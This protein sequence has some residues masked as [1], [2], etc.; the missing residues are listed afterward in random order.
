MAQRKRY[1]ALVALAAM[2]LCPLSVAGEDT[3]TVPQISN[4][5]VLVGTTAAVPA[6]TTAAMDNSAAEKA[7]SRGRTFKEIVQKA[8]PTLK[9]SGYIITQYTY[10]DQAHKSTNGGFDLRLVRLNAQGYCFDK[11]FYRLQMEVNGEP[12]SKKSPRIVDAFIEWQQWDFLR[13][14]LGQFKRSFGFE[15]PMHPLDVGSGSYSQ[16]TTKFLFTDRCG[17]PAS[18]G[19][20]IGLQLQGDLFPA[21]DG[22]KWLHYQVGLFNGQGTNFSDKDKHKDLIGGLWVSPVKNLRI[23]GFGWNGKYTN[24][25]YVATD[26]V[27]MKSCKRIRWGVGIDYESNWVFRSEYLSSVGGKVTNRLASDRSDAW[28]MTLGAPLFKNFKLYGRWD[29]YR[30]TREWASLK[31]NYGLSAN[32]W[33]GKHLL[34]QVNYYFTNERMATDRYYNN[35]DIQV[36]AK[37]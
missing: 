10:N 33:L 25:D 28:Y 13:V 24:A 20:D 8:D 15:N 12:G 26:T 19:R 6:D 35:I 23:G 30:D 17:A 7:P 21:A 32:Y 16:L 18:N 36:A 9:F 22:H 34:F 27:G 5:D 14:K 29:C 2:V 31:Q 3:E 37:F 4:P 11:F 1:T